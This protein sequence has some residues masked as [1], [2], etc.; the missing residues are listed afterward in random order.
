MN[1]C[2]ITESLLQKGKYSNT[3]KTFN[4]IDI[5]V[6]EARMLNVELLERRGDILDCEN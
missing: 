1:L 4:K 3:Y 5:M 6:E 2:Y